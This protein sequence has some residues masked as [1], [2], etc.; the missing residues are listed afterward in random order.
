MEIEPF[1]S[2]KDKLVKM[3]EDSQQRLLKAEI[4]Y[5]GDFIPKKDLKFSEYTAIKNYY[6]PVDFERQSS[7]AVTLPLV[8]VILYAMQRY[9]RRFKWF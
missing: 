2:E 1:Y 9:G 6:T 5:E 7:T 8:S 4:G 3:F